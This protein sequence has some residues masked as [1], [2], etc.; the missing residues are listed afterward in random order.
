M[1]KMDPS[2]TI[3]Q[4]L[5]NTSD[6]IA[7]GTDSPG[8]TLTAMAKRQKT[9]TEDL[10]RSV[11]R[12]DGVAPAD[13]AALQGL[14]EKAIQTVKAEMVLNRGNMQATGIKKKVLNAYGNVTISGTP[15]R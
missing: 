8:E 12:P 10:N 9:L 14:V 15:P 4:L 5:E 6:I 2:A 13:V 7:A 1:D 3:R 11:A